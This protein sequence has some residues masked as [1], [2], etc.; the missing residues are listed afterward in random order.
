MR[1]IL[2][3]C[4]AFPSL[5]ETSIT[6]IASP[7]RKTNTSASLSASN[8]VNKYGQHSSCVFSST[9]TI[10]LLFLYWVVKSKLKLELLNIPSSILLFLDA[11]CFDIEN[12]L[13]CLKEIGRASC[14]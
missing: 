5:N 13:E 4:Q 1:L 9:I 6:F 11:I 8:E 2:L 3:F 10:F 14:R 7:V 12:I